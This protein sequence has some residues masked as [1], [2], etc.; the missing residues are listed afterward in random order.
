MILAALLAALPGAAL[1]QDDNPAGNVANGKKL[2]ETDGCFQCHG[3]AAQGGGAGPKL[4]PPPAF[5]AFLLQLRTPRQ[6]MPPY[7]ASVLSDQQAADIHAYLMTFPKPPDP[8]T[9][10]LLQ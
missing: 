8:K 9:I 4:N 3:W 10:R 2:F 7:A 6:L 1:A 5:P